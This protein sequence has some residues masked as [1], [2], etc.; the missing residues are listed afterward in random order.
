MADLLG[1]LQSATKRTDQFEENHSRDAD[2][3][4]AAR[5]S[6]RVFICGCNL[7]SEPKLLDEAARRAPCLGPSA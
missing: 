4:P 6:L 1:R 3:R 2:A 5:W 7:Q